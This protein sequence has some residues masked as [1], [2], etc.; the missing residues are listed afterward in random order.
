MLRY[1]TIISPIRG[2]IGGI[3]GLADDLRRRLDRLRRCGLRLQVLAA[4][5]GTRHWME[6]QFAAGVQ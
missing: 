5:V 3:D 2:P 4:D 1:G 6:N